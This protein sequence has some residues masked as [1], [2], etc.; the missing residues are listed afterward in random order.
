MPPNTELPIFCINLLR[1]EKR[2]E[3]MQTR[4]NVECDFNI[5]FHVAF[6]RRN[7]GVESW[8]S[9]ALNRQLSSGEIACTLSH[10]ELLLYCEERY[11]EVVILEDDVIPLVRS[12]AALV[13]RIRKACD[14]FP[15]AQFV[16]LGAFRERSKRGD[17]IYANSREVAS[18]G[19][20]APAGSFAYYLTG[21]GI[22]FLRFC[23]QTLQLPSDIPQDTCFASNGLFA[24]LNQPVAVHPWRGPECYTYVG[25]EFRRSMPR[26]YIP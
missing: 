22:A 26:K 17:Q 23:L 25:N 7:I 16:H 2:R 4:W 13:E 14:E 8:F 24:T 11:G 1:A 21:K 15:A 6:D 3:L 20:R 9:K 19:S 12:K 18:A 5:Q 10:L